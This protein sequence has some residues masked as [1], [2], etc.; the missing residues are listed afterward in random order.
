MIYV[1]EILDWRFAKVGFTDDPDISKR[2]AQL[3]TGCPFEIKL[4]LKVNGSLLQEKTIHSVLD[5]MFASM[6]HPIP[7]NEWYPGRSEFFKGFCEALS[8]GFSY[9]MAYCADKNMAARGE[10]CAQMGWDGK[11]KAWPKIAT[12]ADAIEQNNVNDGP[13]H[14]GMKAEMLRKQG[15]HVPK[16]LKAL[17]DLHRESLSVVN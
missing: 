7:P 6:G 16:R 1:L 2:I 10:R 14:P 13:P 11:K 17:L 4:A 5:D 3:Q 9:A 12:W 8:Y 15:K